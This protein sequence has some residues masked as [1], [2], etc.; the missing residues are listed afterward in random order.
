M[1]VIHLGD[2]RD[3]ECPEDAIAMIV[4]PPYNIGKKYGGEIENYPYSSWVRELL[5]WSKAKWNLIFGPWVSIYEWLP[6]VPKPNRILIWHRTFTLPRRKAPL[7]TYATTPI[8]V[9]YDVDAVWHG[10]E[11]AE[12]EWH[13][14]IEAHSA[15]G[16]I[17]KMERYFPNNRPKHPG[18]TG[19]AICSKLI[20]AVSAPRDLIVDPMCGLGSVPIAAL[21]N[22]RRVWGC[23]I[24]EEYRN[25]ALEWI[26]NEG[27]SSSL[28]DYPIESVVVPPNRSRDK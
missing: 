16:D 10:P 1:I 12:R 2:F 3:T 6:Q 5:L 14:C 27:L 7:W 23:E 24:N 26:Y 15:M 28:F 19:T 11:R 9:Y 8:L 13:D 22:G 17:Q 20:M 18:M 25:F 4:D 21:R